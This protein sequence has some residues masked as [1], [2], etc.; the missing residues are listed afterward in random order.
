MDSTSRP[1]LVWDGDIEVLWGWL[2]RWFSDDYKTFAGKGGSTDVAAIGAGWTTIRKG[3]RI[4]VTRA[5]EGYPHL[6]IVN[7][8]QG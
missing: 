3:D 8:G 4:V 1:Y 2:H 7:G 5:I 6:D